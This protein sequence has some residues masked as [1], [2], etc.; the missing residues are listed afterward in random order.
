MLAEILDNARSA[1]LAKDIHIV[2]AERHLDSSDLTVAGYSQKRGLGQTIRDP[3]N[4]STPISS[5]II[6]SHHTRLHGNLIMGPHRKSASAKSDK[7]SLT[8][9]A[10]DGFGFMVVGTRIETSV[11]NIPVEALRAGDLVRTMDHGYKPLRYVKV[12]KAL[13]ER[14]HALV[15][16]RRGALGQD[17]DLRVHPEQRVVIS[18]WPAELL[19]GTDEIL[20]TARSLVNARNIFDYHRSAVDY[21]TVLLDS[22][23]IIFAEGVPI[24]SPSTLAAMSDHGAAGQKRQL[25]ALWSETKEDI[26][27]ASKQSA[28][29]CLSH[30]ECMVVAEYLAGSPT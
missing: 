28:R 16:I 23:Q 17:H 12:S 3:S 11:G 2:S 6:Q 14:S 26:P 25:G 13:H 1:Y 10:F 21:V 8:G 4:Q 22:Q 20:A 18:G 15:L 24:E 9:T 27:L 19:F 30:T 29:P 7:P 5:S